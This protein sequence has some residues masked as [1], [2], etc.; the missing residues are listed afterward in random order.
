MK[1]KTILLLS[2]LL[3]VF[4]QNKAQQMLVENLQ[5][6][7]TANELTAFKKFAKA[8][9]PAKSNLGNAWVYG[10]SGSAME[11]IGVMYEATHD[12]ELLDILIQLAD[13]ALLARNNPVNGRVL[14]NGKRE[15]CWP[16]KSNTV[17]D[18]LY[19]GSENGDIV[20]H[21]AYCA[22]LI[23]KNKSLWNT[24]VT[25]GDPNQFG[26]TYIKRANTYLTEM[27]KTLQTYIIPYFV[28][29]ESL[30]FYWPDLPAWKA[31]G[32][33]Y[34][35][36]GNKPIPWNQQAM[37][38]GGF[39]RMAECYDL[40]NQ[41]PK[42][43]ALYDQIVKT[44]VDWFISQLVP[45]KSAAGFDCYKWSYPV[46]D[47]AGKY[48][49]DVPH[50]GYDVLGITRNYTRAAYAIPKKVMVGLAN[51]AQY[52][53]YNEKEKSF[54]ARVDGLNGAKQSRK[55]I[56]AYFLYLSAFNPELYTIIANATIEN[57]K[58]KMEDCAMILTL[59][60]EK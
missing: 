7:I 26:E 59:K 57:A 49:E 25:T 45:Y 37:L 41:Q 47:F 21:I 15:L 60:P 24:K 54:S 30:K 50:A 4:N 6:P 42:K 29:K 14:W 33:R 10:T 1:K 44:S 38:T 43:V 23:I 58:T 18:S 55:S 36:D 56:G 2:F 51:T 20:A 28:Q 11:A 27:D 46:N 9:V 17:I 53:I 52:V 35:G 3:F 19:S 22:K 39:Q 5:G 34:A 48:I 8:F 40:L 12:N 16:N 13:K 31:I 32:P